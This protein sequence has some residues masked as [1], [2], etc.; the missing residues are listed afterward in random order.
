MENGH[1]STTRIDSGDYLRAL[2]AGT[3]DMVLVINDGGEINYANPVAETTLI[4]HLDHLVGVQYGIPALEGKFLFSLL[5]NGHGMAVMKVSRLGKSTLVIIRELKQSIRQE[6]VPLS[7]SGLARVGTWRLDLFSYLFYWS[8]LTREFLGLQNALSPRFEDFVKFIPEEAHAKVQEIINRNWQEDEVYDFGLPLDPGTEEKIWLHVVC[9]PEFVNGQL[10]ALQGTFQDISK[11]HQAEVQLLASER[12]FKNVYDNSINGLSLCHIVTDEKGAVTDLIVE[13][14]NPAYLEILRLREEDVLGKSVWDIIYWEDDGS[15]LERLFD[16]AQTNESVHFI[17]H[18][19]MSNRHFGVSAYCA[20]PNQLAIDIKDITE[21][22][23]SQDALAKSEQKYR[24]L[25][26]HSINGFALHEVVF[27]SEGRPVNFRFLD[28]NSAFETYTGIKAED[29][30]GKL[31]TEGLPGIEDSGLIDLYG[32]VATT[33]EPQRFETYY[34]P[35]ERYYLI[36]AFSPAPNQFATIFADFTERIQ[37]EKAVQLSEQNFRVLFNSMLQGIVYQDD[38]GRIISANKAAEHILGFSLEE[39]QGLSSFDDIWKTI[40][41]NGDPLSGSEHPA[42]I[43]LRTGKTVEGYAFGVFNPKRNDIVWIDVCSV[44]QYHEGEEEPYQVFTTFLDITDQIRVQQS[45]EERIKELHSLA[46]VSRI[47]QQETE[48]EPICKLVAR[49]LVRGLKYPEVAVVTIELGGQ[50]WSTDREAEE[51]RFQLVVPIALEDE[52]AGQLLAFYKED[53]QFIIPE[54]MNLLEGAAERLGLWYQQQKTQGRLRESERRFR[55]AIR[56]A[57]NPIMIHAEDGEIIEVNDAWLNGT[58]YTRDELHT[59]SDWVK[60][61]HP[62]AVNNVEKQP[63]TNFSDALKGH[64]GEFPVR[65]KSGD[66]LHWYFSSAPLGN[67]PDGRVIATTVVIDIT[68]RVRA[69]EEKRQYYDRI[70][71]L[72]EIDQVIVST[73]ELD[74]VLNLITSHLAK[75]IKYDSLSILSIDGDELK[76]IACEGFEN[77]EDVLKM[78]FPSKPG[79]PNYE[80]IK[81]QTPIALTNVSKDYP[82]FQ[83]PRGQSLRGEIKAWLGIPLFNR[84]EVIGMFTIDRCEEEPYSEQDIEV[85]MQY[86]NRAAIAI[87]NARLFEQ[88]NNHLRKLEIL[89]KIDGTITSSK[90]VSD[91][92]HTVLEQVKV[93]LNVDVAS[94]FLADENEQ[95]LT[96]Q[97]SFGYRTEGNLDH[98]VPIGQGYVGT[99]AAQ[100]K[101]LFIPQVNLVDDG[102][103]YPFSL[104]NEGVVSYFGFPL[105]TKGKLQGVLQVLQRTRLNPSEEWIEFAEAL[106]AQTAIAVENLTLFGELEQANKE[107]REAYEA[108]IE[109]WAHALEIRDKETEGHSRRVVILTEEVA[110]TFGLNG[111]A[112][113]HLRRGVLLHDIGKMGVPDQILHKPGPLDEAEWEV[114][115]Q[116]PIYAVKMLEQIEYLRPA[117]QVPKYHHERWDGSGYPEGLKGEAIPL[118]ARIFAVVDAYDALT[119]DRPYRDAW[120]QEETVA[121]LRKQAGKE[122]DPVVVEKFLEILEK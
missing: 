33:G 21:S 16:V 69:E 100:R 39:L 42:I 110:K 65:T 67:L 30:I 44:P 108:T 120:T 73:L 4:P 104:A 72:S 19:P 78:R 106:A 29:V 66:R 3:A 45:L 119:S 92:L 8:D 59:V 35:L 63:K 95:V 115:R 7:M 88:T 116:H 79:Y 26:E 15:L 6:A 111:E 71:A 112:L 25:F 24:Q 84:H 122:F 113:V 98:K 101:S 1:Q 52:E 61:A 64:D 89:R 82:T 5:S 86:A 46:K 10:V 107:L 40:K 62:Q 34:A 97:Q 53:R 31:A 114:M 41:M 14:I 105:I 118:E 36:T 55:N 60:L 90:N 56:N 58:G 85:A 12:Q 91:A 77:K 103:K 28:V 94:V 43:A 2:M 81:H 37:A 54:E 22:I 48:L 87:T 68:N 51:T 80:V 38:K 18:A 13:Y 70:I 96:Y 99:V 17:Y 47:I 83:Q 109:G 23:N 75:L 93:G 76:V 121:Y 57:P 74:E 102:H 49:E 20:G 27:D 117:L 9:Q 50:K 11:Q 32:K